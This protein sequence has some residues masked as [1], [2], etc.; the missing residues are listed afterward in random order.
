MPRDKDGIQGGVYNDR[1][2]RYVERPDGVAK[3][4]ERSRLNEHH[5]T[6]WNSNASEQQILLSSGK[7]CSPKTLHPKEGFGKNNQADVNGNR[8]NEHQCQAIAQRIAGFI[9]IACS[10]GAR[11]EGACGGRDGHRHRANRKD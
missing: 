2:Y 8:Q 5:E 9:D 1:P 7:G 4:P 6:E 3:P 10:H 11:D